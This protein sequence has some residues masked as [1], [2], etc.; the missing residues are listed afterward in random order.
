MKIL[1]GNN[2]TNTYCCYLYIYIVFRYYFTILEIGFLN[3]CYE[4]V[5][6]IELTK[7]VNSNFQCIQLKNSR[8]DKMLL[9]AW[10]IISH[11]II[12]Y[13]INSCIQLGWTYIFSPWYIFPTKIIIVKIKSHTANS[14]LMYDNTNPYCFEQISTTEPKSHYIYVMLIH[15]IQFI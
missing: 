15:L 11:I 5:H 2:R 14:E 3:Q 6:F 10:W 1:I 7:W 4:S 8:F 12:I 9:P 13:L